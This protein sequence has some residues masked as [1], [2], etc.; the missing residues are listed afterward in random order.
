MNRP[1]APPDTGRHFYVIQ[2]RD[3]GNA[4]VYLFPP[5]ALATDCGSRVS[6]AS[7]S[8]ELRLQAQSPQAGTL[9]AFSGVTLVVRGVVPW[10]GMEADIRARYYA[11]CESADVT[12][13]EKGGQAW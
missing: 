4:D 7:C 3:D 13:I 6:P 8:D 9:N 12:E 5:R 2:Q 1:N 11:W 10:D